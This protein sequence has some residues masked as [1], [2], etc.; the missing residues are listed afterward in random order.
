MRR[1][2]GPGGPVLPG[3]FQ[4]QQLRLHPQL[5]GRGQPVDEEYAVEVVHLVLDDPGDLRGGAISRQQSSTF[6]WVSIC[7]RG[8]SRWADA[9]PVSPPTLVM[10]HVGRR[11]A[12]RRAA[13]GWTQEELAERAEVSVGYVRQVEGGG[14]T[15]RSRPSSSSPCSSG[16]N[17]GILFDGP[18]DAS[19]ARETAEAG[20]VNG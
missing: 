11:V 2:T 20:W 7:P 10:R 17:Q 12:E 1:I 5:V 6:G 3:G 19:P 9:P 14:E 16:R 18:D 15:R 8:S 4:L 13:Q